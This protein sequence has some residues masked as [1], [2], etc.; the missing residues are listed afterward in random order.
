V[1]PGNSVGRRYWQ[2]CALKCLFKVPESLCGLA[3]ERH[4]LL[5]HGPVHLA[6]ERHHKISHPVEPLPAPGVELGRLSV[7]RRQR[8]DLFVEAG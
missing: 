7:A 3:G 2:R 6:A 1:L 5:R 4:K 8:V